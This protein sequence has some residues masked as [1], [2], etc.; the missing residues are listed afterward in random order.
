MQQRMFLSFGAKNNEVKNSAAV[1]KFVH[2]AAPLAP[3]Y[4]GTVLLHGHG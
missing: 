4:A 3:L 1:A 2:G